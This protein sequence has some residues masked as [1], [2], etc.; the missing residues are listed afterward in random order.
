MS[1]D[2]VETDLYAA[3]LPGFP[4]T[5]GNVD[6]ATLFQRLF[7]PVIHTESSVRQG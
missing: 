1:I 2:I 4:A 6:N 3:G 7:Y 5:G